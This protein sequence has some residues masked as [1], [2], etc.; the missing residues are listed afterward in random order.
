MN[1]NFGLF[2]ELE[3]PRADA[4]GRRLKGKERGRARKK[5]LTQRAVIDAENW[6]RA[7]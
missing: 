2:P 7:S 6:L 3:A 5:L 4:D 1:V